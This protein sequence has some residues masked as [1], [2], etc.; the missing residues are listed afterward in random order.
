MHRSRAPPPPPYDR[1]G[2]IGAHVTLETGHGRILEGGPYHIGVGKTFS[3]EDAF[4]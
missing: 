4:D 3:T 2:T 1:D